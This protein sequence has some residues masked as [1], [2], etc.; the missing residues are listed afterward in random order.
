MKLSTAFLQLHIFRLLFLRFVQLTGSDDKICG[1]SDVKLG[2][3]CH[4]SAEVTVVSHGEFIL[5]VMSL[6]VVSVL[7]SCGEQ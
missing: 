4:L 6:P 7:V 3:V 2:H 5:N 1:V